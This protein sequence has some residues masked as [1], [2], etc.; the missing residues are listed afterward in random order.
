MSEDAPKYL[1][2]EEVSAEELN[3]RNMISKEMHEMFSIPANQLNLTQMF[4]ETA[5]QAIRLQKQDEERRYARPVVVRAPYADSIKAEVASDQQ[6]GF[7][8]TLSEEK[9]GEWVELDLPEEYTV[10][11]SNIVL[12]QAVMDGDVWYITNNA[13]IE[14]SLERVAN[15]YDAQ[16]K[17]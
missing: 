3:I 8:V 9:D 4:L 12:T 6:G 17:D 10:H 13:T 1:N 16:L 11:L 15:H 7:S 5:L 14:A 2:N